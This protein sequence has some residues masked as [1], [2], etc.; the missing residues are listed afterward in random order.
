MLGTPPI[1][2]LSRYKKS[3]DSQLSTNAMLLLY[4]TKL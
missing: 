4:A 1:Y 3:A 2:D